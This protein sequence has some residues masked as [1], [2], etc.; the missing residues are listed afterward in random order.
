[1]FLY[2]KLRCTIFCEYRWLL[3]NLV[4]P[5]SSLQIYVK[6]VKEVALD[7]KC[8]D[9]IDQIKSKINSIEGIDKSHQAL[10][11]GGNHL[12][13]NNRLVD[14]NITTNSS[15]DLYVTDG[16][17]I[18]VSIPSVGKIIKLNLKKSQ[19]VADVKA[20]IENKGGIPLDEQILM[21]GCQQ[22]EDNKVLSQ[23][24]LSN[25][26]TL[27]VLVR[28]TGKLRIYVS[29][30][31]ERT[32]N[33]DVKNWYTVADVKLMIE[34][35]EGV[36][37]CSQ[38][39]MRTQPG[40]AETLEDSETL[41]NQYIRNNGTLTLYQNIQFFVK[42]YEGRTLTMSMKTCGTVDDVMEKVEERSLAKVGVYYLYYRGRVLCLGDT[43][44]KHK[45]V[46]N[47][48]IEVRLHN[49]HAVF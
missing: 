3:S 10:F 23:C 32:V 38:I 4:V 6:M 21:C 22:L 8:T 42:S 12:E 1:M 29:V 40:G 15:V 36:P 47:S 9:T 17:Q 20:E 45:V 25:G 48:T 35:L 46:N 5:L 33:L 26:D 19:N 7:V 16:I 31:V 41:Q 37:A 11:F 14:Y 49:S 30:D 34:T 39:L 24:G 18:S 43:L 2:C 13:N 44:H 28:P 27:H